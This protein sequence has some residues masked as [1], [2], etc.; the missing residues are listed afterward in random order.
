MVLLSLDLELDASSNGKAYFCTIATVA[1]SGLEMTVNPKTDGYY[2]DGDRVGYLIPPKFDQ[3]PNPNP[4]EPPPTLT[5]FNELKRRNV[6]RV[7]IAYVVSAWLL[8]QV[9][10]VVLNNFELPGWVFRTTL[11]VLA[12]GFP[13]EG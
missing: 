7:G 2:Q 11:L 4:P 12:I 6:I 3:P 5:F 13:D 9:A 1:G 8:L 10:D